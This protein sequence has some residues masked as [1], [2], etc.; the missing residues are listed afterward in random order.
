M[1]LTN[2]SNTTSRLL[3]PAVAGTFLRFE[4]LGP[5]AA[6]WTMAGLYLASAMLLGLLPRSVVRENVG[7]THVLQDLRE[8]LAYAWRH[9]QLRHL[10]IFFV[11]VMLV[12]FP[13]VA[14][15]NGWLETEVGR[16]REDVAIVAIFSAIGAFT[17]SLSLARF[18]DA[19][20]K[21]MFPE[22]FADL[23]STR[24]FVI[25]SLYDSSELW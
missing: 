7:E 20:W 2:V 19:P 16:P 23:I 15:M 5:A 12:G 25:N 8:G 11:S 14:L 17:A 9:V 18:A 4:S 22:Y 1:T 10:L 13:H 21:C 3:G 6:Y 24:F